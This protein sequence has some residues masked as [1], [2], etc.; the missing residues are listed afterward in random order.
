VLAHKWLVDWWEE[1]VSDDDGGNNADGI[2][3]QGASDGVAGLFDSDRT[4]VHRNDVERRVGGSLEHATEAAGKTVRAEVLHGVDH[5]ATG[6]ASAE[7]LHEGRGEGRN[8]VVSDTD[9]AE[10]G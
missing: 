4:E 2:R 3:N 5:H 1:Y 10:Q 8:D 9:K 7:G 6:T